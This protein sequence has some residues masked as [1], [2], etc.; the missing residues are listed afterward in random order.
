[1]ERYVVLCFDIVQ[2]LIL[3]YASPPPSP[4]TSS[5]GRPLLSQATT[6]F[7]YELFVP[8]KEKRSLSNLRRFKSLFLLSDMVVTGQEMVKEK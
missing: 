7:Q 1:M 8:L 3:I 4:L 5:T 6:L 2:L